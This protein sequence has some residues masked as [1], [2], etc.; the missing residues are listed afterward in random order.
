MGNS[1][2]ASAGGDERV[3]N[4]KKTERDGPVTER[5]RAEEAGA[6][7]RVKAMRIVTVFAWQWRYV[8]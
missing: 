7:R 5:S 1:M 3:A 2:T 6:A 8:G 4:S